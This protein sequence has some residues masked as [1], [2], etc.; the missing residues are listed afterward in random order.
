MEKKKLLTLLMCGIVIVSGLTACSSNGKPQGEGKEQVIGEGSEEDIQDKDIR[1]LHSKSG[2]SCG[3]KDGYYSIHSNEDGMMNIMY[4]DYNTKKQI[5][6]CDKSECKH[7]NEKCTSFID[8]KYGAMEKTILCDDKYL[9]FIASE[10]NNE[11]GVST[12]I[13]Y[14]DSGQEKEDKPTTIYRMNLDGSNKKILATL[15][16]GEVL[17]DSFFTDGNYIYAVAMKTVTT[18]LEEN[19]SYTYSDNSRLIGISNDSGEI[20]EVSK[21]DSDCRV[22]GTFDNKVIALK[23]KFN[24][25]VTIEDKVDEEKYTELLKNAEE[26]IVSFDIKTGNFE[27]LSSSKSKEGYYY[28]M[29]GKD[30]FYSSYQGDKIMA[31]DLNSNKEYVFLESKYSNIQQIYDGYIIS[32]HWSDD[33]EDSY[34]INIDDKSVNKFKLIKNNGY[35]VN[36]ISESKDLFFVESNCDVESEYVEWADVT[37]EIH[38]NK[39]YSLISKEDFFKGNKN[40]QG[41]K[42]IVQELN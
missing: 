8:F 22:L 37:Q 27:E 13:N 3:S 5:Y 38:T 10:Y 21:W 40:F 15:S 28:N 9:Y 35:P 20:R 19:S 41:V 18:A 31:F 26:A 39:Q 23:L 17:G 1:M 30:I 29:Y 24:K 25:E 4:V 33:N 36:I 34:I 16:T 14:G 7:D 11:N 12:S 42:L 32:S 6:L 2:E